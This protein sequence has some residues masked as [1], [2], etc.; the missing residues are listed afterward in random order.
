MKKP[1]I[2]IVA[3]G[4]GHL[5]P[6]LSLFADHPALW[7]GVDLGVRTIIL[8]GIAPHIAVGDFDSVSEEEWQQIEKK[9]PAIHK[10]RP[11]KDETDMELALMWAASQE[12]DKIV[13]FGGTGGRLDHFLANAFMMAGYKQKYPAITFELI[14]KNNVLS[15]VLP[16][17]YSLERDPLKKYVS[18]IPVFNKVTGL[19]LT[20][21]K[22][23]LN[24]HTV[25]PGSSLCI[26]NELIEKTGHFSFEKGILMVIRS[27]D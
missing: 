23:P 2:H 5:I 12:P 27:I 16:G 8:A 19:T 7:A 17:S 9:V 26:S 15:V 1:I 3:G 18:F 24:D 13:I 22:Y 10:F 20:G 21:F 25:P 11:E 6:D 4:P 14:D